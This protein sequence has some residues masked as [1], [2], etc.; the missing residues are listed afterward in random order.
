MRGSSAQIEDGYK[1]MISAIRPSSFSS[2]V[3][4]VRPVAKV[5]AA[6]GRASIEKA[7]QQPGQLAESSNKKLGRHLDIL[8]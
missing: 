8:I 3:L 6:Q 1:K 4:R 2:T 5:S 7:T